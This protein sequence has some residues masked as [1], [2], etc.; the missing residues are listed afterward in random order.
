MEFKI[1]EDIDDESKNNLKKD[2]SK[3]NIIIIVIIA[4][5]AGLIVFFVFNAIFNP[6]TKP[7]KVEPITEEK[8]SLSEKNVTTLYQYVTYG[9]TGIRNDKY[10]KN[11]SVKVKDFTDEEKYYYGLMFVQVRDFDFTGEFDANK[12]KIYSISNRMIKK[13]IERYF[14]KGTK[15]ST[16]VKIDKYPYTFSINDNNLGTMRYDETTDS[17]LTTFSKE[18]NKNDYIIS[19]YLGELT[20]A[21]KEV[22]GSYR[23]VEKLVYVDLKKQ[24]DN[25][26]DV[27]ISKDYEHNNVIES[28][29][30]LTESDV[31]KLSVKKYLKNAA[32]ITYHFRLDGNVLVFDYS[33]IK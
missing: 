4:L 1:S 31:R 27:V 3:F 23:I 21:Y 5:I 26:Y 22:D 15:Y 28:S 13:Y 7:K 24:A 30:D 32:T 29:T 19:P 12:N 16:D 20:E 14:G 9:T 6:K 8:R 33:E 2:N 25:S 11:K 17:F 10:V 18:E